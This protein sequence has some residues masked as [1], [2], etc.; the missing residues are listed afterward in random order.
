M[1]IILWGLAAFGLLCFAGNVLA[2]IGNVVV[3]L[4]KYVACPLVIFVIICYFIQYGG[5]G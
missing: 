5:K 1:S 3:A 2:A 4:L